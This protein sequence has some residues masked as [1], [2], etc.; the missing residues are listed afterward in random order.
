MYTAGVGQFQPRVSY[1]GIRPRNNMVDTLK[2]FANTFGVEKDRLT[3]CSP[4]QETLGY[5]LAN[6]FGV[7]RN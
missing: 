4:G 3:P 6:T 7:R 2:E 1:P 5:Q